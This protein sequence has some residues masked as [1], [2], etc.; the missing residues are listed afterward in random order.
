MDVLQMA[1]AAK[2]D[3][4]GLQYPQFAAS[5]DYPSAFRT[6][7]PLPYAQ[8]QT[9]LPV[10]TRKSEPSDLEKLIGCG[11][12]VAGLALQVYAELYLIP[13]WQV[14]VDEELRKAARDNRAGDALTLL[15]F[16]YGLDKASDN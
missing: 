15:L 1:M 3:P 7:E 14:E 16:K 6:A 10:Q 13:K 2:R 11:L 4:F 8:P 12:Q 5:F 9:S